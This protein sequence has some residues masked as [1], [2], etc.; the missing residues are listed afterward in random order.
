M[1]NLALIFWVATLVLV[2]RSGSG[3]LVLSN[4]LTSGDYHMSRGSTVF[5]LLGVWDKRTRG[6][7]IGSLAMS[8]AYG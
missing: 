7:G 5:S 8:Y 1:N 2:T 3:I 4:N 6:R